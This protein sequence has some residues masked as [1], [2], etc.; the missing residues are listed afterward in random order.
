MDRID[1][2]R[3]WDDVNER[4]CK[5]NKVEFKSG[6]LQQLRVSKAVPS[7]RHYGKRTSTT[8]SLGNQ[9]VEVEINLSEVRIHQCTQ[10]GK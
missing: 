1:E 5:I 6:N 3:V 2:Q 9:Q 10:C 8:L 7:N 4:E